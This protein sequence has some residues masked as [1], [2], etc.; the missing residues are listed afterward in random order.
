MRRAAATLVLAAALVGGC[1]T[2]APTT[3]LAPSPGT[4]AGVAAVPT[5]TVVPS[6]DPTATPE[7]TAEPTPEPF[8]EQMG[9]EAFTPIASGSW[10]LATSAD[11]IDDGN[12]RITNWRP[13]TAFAE[14]FIQCAGSG[15][16]SVSVTAG[17]PQNDPD[18]ATATPAPLGAATLECP[19][20]AGL[21]IS[22]AGTAPDGWFAS[23]DIEVSDP[24]IVYQVLVATIVD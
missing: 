11:N 4:S 24:S 13:M 22:L 15:R 20:P 23:P 6:P 7:P 17:V 3:S 16:M 1:A 18:A 9:T 8:L 19:N 12:G 21:I 14:I 5:P 10:E 2:P